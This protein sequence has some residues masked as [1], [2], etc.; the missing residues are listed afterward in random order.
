MNPAQLSRQRVKEENARLQ[1]KQAACA[2][3]RPK[4]SCGYSRAP[5][6]SADRYRSVYNPSWMVFGLANPRFSKAA[7]RYPV[8]PRAPTNVLCAPRQQA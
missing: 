7:L 5:A 6:R 4:E 2:R 3:S 8:V 1:R